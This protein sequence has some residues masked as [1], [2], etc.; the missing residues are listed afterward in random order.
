MRA[1]WMTM[2]M[3]A[4]LVVLALAFTASAQAQGPLGC[5]NAPHPTAAEADVRLEIEPE[6]LIVAGESGRSD[7]SI[8]SGKIVYDFCY[9]QVHDLVENDPAWALTAK[10]RANEY[11]RLVG[12]ST[13]FTWAEGDYS[14][15]H[16]LL[17]PIYRKLK[18]LD[19]ID[20]IIPEPLGGAHRNVAEA[21]ANLERFLIRG[22][23]ELKRV[24]IETLLEHRYKR[25]RR[26]GKFQ[27]L[28]APAAV[29]A[30]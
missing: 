29:N 11:A 26:M 15:K 9:G 12:A 30:G 24:S 28:T 27:L 16:R 22:I 7:R 18:E 14:V 3:M 17:L 8:A 23:R 19:V 2:I 13:P 25:W 10:Q 6:L 20:A 1:F 4:G 21:Y 5:E